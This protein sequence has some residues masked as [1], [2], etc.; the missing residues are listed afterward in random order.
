MPSIEFNDSLAF[1]KKELKETKLK[2]LPRLISESQRKKFIDFL[3][4]KPKGKFRM[5]YCTGDNE[6]FEYSKQ[7]SNLLIDAGYRL[8]GSVDNFVGGDAATGILIVI[9][10]IKSLPVYA[11]ILVDAFKLIGIKVQTVT[12]AKITKPYDLLVFIGHKK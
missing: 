10:S 12:D 1:A 6:A 9:N 11:D 8:S 5:M 3:R 4:F 2:L 7:I